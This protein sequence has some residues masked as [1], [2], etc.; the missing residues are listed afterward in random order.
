MICVLKVVTAP[1]TSQ[2]SG[3]GQCTGLSPSALLIRIEATSQPSQAVV[4]LT[5]GYLFVSLFKVGQCV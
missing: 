5:L 1:L 4:I 3:A 2:V